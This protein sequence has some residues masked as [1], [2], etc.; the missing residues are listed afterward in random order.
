MRTRQHLPLVE[1]ALKLWVGCRFIE[2]PWSITGSERL[3]MCRDENPNCPYHDRIPVPPIVD[4]QIDLIVIN[5]L[6]QPKLKK[7]LQT[8][9][10]MLEG[11]DPWNDWFQI[12]LACF[13]LLHNVELT[14]AHDAWFVKRNNLKVRPQPFENNRILKLISP[15]TSRENIPI[16]L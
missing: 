14:M 5:E 15:R 12:Y 11:S 1:R 8:L 9:K 2:K 4:L 6:L 16:S 7:I 10:T 13:I 3:G